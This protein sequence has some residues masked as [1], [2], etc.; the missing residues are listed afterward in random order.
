[1][2]KL[3]FKPV[4]NIIGGSYFVCPESE[5][6]WE[7]VVFKTDKLGAYLLSLLQNDISCE[8]MA[9]IAK[10]NFPN[11]SQQNILNKA[12]KVKNTISSITLEEN[13]LEVIEI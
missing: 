2:D 12:I 8:E 9:R 4:I 13:I 6:S 1:M 10:E 11:E 5:N 7:R 3:N